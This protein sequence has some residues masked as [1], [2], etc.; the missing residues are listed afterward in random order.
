[1]S[2]EISKV[3]KKM[4]AS[5]IVHF[6]VFQS[7]NQNPVYFTLLVYPAQSLYATVSRYS[8]MV[9]AL[10]AAAAVSIPA[11]Q[12]FGGIPEQSVLPGGPIPSPPNPVTTT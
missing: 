3:K 10:T 6:K 11:D 2:L 5:D 12:T 7:R 1:V 8:S 9:A 4:P